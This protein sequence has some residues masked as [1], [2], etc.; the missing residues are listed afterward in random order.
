MTTPEE[1]DL[2]GKHIDLP[3]G[4][5]AADACLTGSSVSVWAPIGYFQVV[6]DDVARVAADYDLP[7]EAVGAA[8]AYYREHQRAIDARIE[9][10]DAA[11]AA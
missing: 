2:I 1:A 7:P 8:I 3:P 9:A 4:G 11:F 5:S 10:H 6:G